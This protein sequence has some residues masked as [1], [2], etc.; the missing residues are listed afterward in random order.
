M[1][2]APVGMDLAQASFGRVQFAGGDFWVWFG[3]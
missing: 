1:E 3:V 2:S